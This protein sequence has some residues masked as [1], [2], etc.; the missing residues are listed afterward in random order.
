MDDATIESR[1][2]KLEDRDA[3]RDLARR[4]AHCVWQKDVEGAIEL[5]T[6]DGEMDTGERDVIRG[7]DALLATYR[8]MVGDAQ[9]QPFV[10]NHVVEVLGDNA[11]GTCY[12]DLRSI[13]EGRSMIGSGY[14][15]DHYRRVGEVWKFRSRKLVLS[16]LVPLAEGWAEAAEGQK[17]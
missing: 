4:Y 14:Y 10:H 6:D 13:S 16:Y 17:S 11:T 8:S 7:K 15:E 3:I 5:F 1:I 12:L 2:R 9:F